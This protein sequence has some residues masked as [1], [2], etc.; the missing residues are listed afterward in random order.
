[1]IKIICVG[2]IKESYLKELILD[3]QKRIQK[4][5]KLEIIEVK[6]E[7]S[8]EKEKNNLLKVLDLKDYIITL[9]IEGKSYSSEE[10]SQHLDQ[11]FLKTSNITF[12]IGSSLGIPEEIKKLKKESITFSKFTFP[13]G[14]F[15][16]ILLEQ[17]YRS[18]KILNHET[19]HK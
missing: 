3:Y 18:F 15:R 11:L 2:K 4:Y 6:D 8:L 9:E 7:E 16:G 19:Y 5:H 14:L 10:F 1:M 13:H 17:I 12:I